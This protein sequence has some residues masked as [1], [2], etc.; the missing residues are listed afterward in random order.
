VLGLLMLWLA[1]GVADAVFATAQARTGQAIALGAGLFV[2][3]PL[4]AAFAVLTLVGIPLG[5][6]LLLAL[7]PLFALG[8][9]T[10]AY[11]LG[12]VMVYAR[13]GRA[14]AF[15]AGWG[16]LRAIAFL[17]ILGTVAWLGATVFGLGLLMLAFWRARSPQEPPLQAA[18][19]P[20]AA[21]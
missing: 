21:S 20:A 1:P 11:V 16:L 12:R 19:E 8:Y 14:P 2:G 4:A 17:P 9:V 5:L 15:L 10:T 18:H 7:L 3:I 6:L 13:T